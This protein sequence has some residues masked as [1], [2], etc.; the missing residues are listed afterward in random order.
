MGGNFAKWGTEFKSDNPIHVVLFRSRNKDNKDLEGFKE[1]REAFIT[2]DYDGVRVSN[3]FNNFVDDGVD[4]EI[5]RMY[6]SVNE[7]D[8]KA[9]Y[10][11]LLHFLIDEPEFNL[12]A[13]DAKLASIAAKKEC[14]KTKH[15]M[16]DFDSL[17]E[18]KLKEFEH[19][20]LNN[21]SVL[22]EHIERHRTPNGYAIIVNHGFDTRELLAKWGDIVSLKKDDLLCVKWTTT[23]S[24]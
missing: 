11:E 10:K 17:D 13:I 1:R 23:T 14:A 3:R 16:F 9:I 8:P 15:W 12:C 19:D 20:I 4:G 7:R 5:C 18:D 24:I 2:N 22:I 21:G 6:V